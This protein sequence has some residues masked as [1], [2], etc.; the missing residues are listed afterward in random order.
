MT[1]T[2]DP[3]AS[4]RRPSARRA[5]RAL[6][7]LIGIGTLLFT[8]L[9]IAALLFLAWFFDL[10]PPI[11]PTF[12]QQERA[13]AAIEEYVQDSWSGQV[14]VLSVDLA[15][16][17]F[18]TDFP[19]P[20]ETKSY[21]YQ[22]HLGVR[23]TGVVIYAPA[24]ARD[25]VS[26]LVYRLPPSSLDATQVALLEAYSRETSVPASSWLHNSKEGFRQDQFPGVDLWSVAP[27]SPDKAKDFD[28][29]CYFFERL[30]DGTFRFIKKSY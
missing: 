2:D 28:G 24:F 22:T 6:F 30:P 19:Y 26:D 16:K 10:I 1:A 11:R 5:W 3:Q 21:E 23:G 29:S 14:E 25:P 17:R 7:N 15:L 13:T 27:G 9:G 4:T 20:H 8:L 18:G 12:V